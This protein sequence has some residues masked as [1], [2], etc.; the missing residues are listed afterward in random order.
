MH[1]NISISILSFNIYL[2]IISE[3]DFHLYND[4]IAEGY[5]GLIIKSVNMNFLENCK[6]EELLNLYL[7][8]LIK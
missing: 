6:D 8:G 2:R 5:T 1:D 7:K 3:F 4:N